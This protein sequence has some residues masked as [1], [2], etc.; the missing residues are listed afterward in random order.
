VD[1]QAAHRGCRGGL[2]EREACLLTLLWQIG[3]IPVMATLHITLET[4]GFEETPAQLL[5]GVAARL[6]SGHLPGEAGTWLIRDFTGDI[7][8][9]VT[10]T[11]KDA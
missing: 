3:T 10:M 5:H 1:A 2:S 11:M 7:A 4:E 6:E 8:G 9:E